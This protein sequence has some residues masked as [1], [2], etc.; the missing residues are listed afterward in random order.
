[1]MTDENYTHEDLVDR[2]ADE[3]SSANDYYRAATSCV[4]RTHDSRRPG[5]Q[6]SLSTMTI[7]PISS[8]ARGSRAKR[9]WFVLAALS[10]SWLLP[11]LQ[12]SGQFQLIR[13]PQHHSHRV[14][15]QYHLHALRQL[16]EAN[17]R[18]PGERRN[19]SRCARTLPCLRSMGEP[20]QPDPLLQS[21]SAASVTPPSSLAL[22]V[23]SPTTRA[24]QSDL[25]GPIP[26]YIDEISLSLRPPSTRS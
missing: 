1:M 7:C 10:S 14:A 24:V 26:P 6:R 12:L 20:P 2:L 18:P 15:V 5:A 16:F 21:R 25:F 11:V 9:L 8:E 22:T 17:E 3:G 19:L 13:R 23:K 4:A